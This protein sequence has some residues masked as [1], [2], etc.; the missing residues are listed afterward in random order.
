[1]MSVLNVTKNAESLVSEMTQNVFP[2]ICSFWYKFHL[3]DNFPGCCQRFN[4]CRVIS[5][6]ILTTRSFETGLYFVKL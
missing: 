1:M 3:K 4:L 6:N 5:F 2:E